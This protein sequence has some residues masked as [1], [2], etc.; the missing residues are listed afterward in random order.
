MIAAF[1]VKEG[2]SEELLADLERVGFPRETMLPV[3]A[4]MRQ[5]VER[6][7]G[8]QAKKAKSSASSANQNQSLS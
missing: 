5:A 8:N 1:N 7:E 3:F 2:P 6:E 4:D